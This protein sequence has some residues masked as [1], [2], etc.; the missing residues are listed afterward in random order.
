MREL[1]EIYDRLYRAYGPQGWWPLIKQDH[2][3]LKCRY[4]REN[5]VKK[6]SRQERFEICTG[7]ILTQNTS[8]NNAERALVSLAQAGILDA[9]AL[10]GM[11]VDRIAGYIRSSGYYNQKA[12]KLKAFS[13]FYQSNPTPQ[14]DLFLE[15]WGLGP[16]TVDDMLLYAYSKPI[17]VI[18]I[19][20]IRLFSRLGLCDEKIT[21]HEL[22]KSIMSHLPEDTLMY[23]EYH[24]LIVKHAKEHCRKNPN[25]QDCPLE[26]KCMEKVP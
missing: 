13:Q 26:K 3:G 25:C 22:Q 8:W 10:A 23:K 18:D 4:V 9:D 20:T 21:Y 14:R 15:Q 2:D 17:F 6:L 12:K 24:A 19:Y 11:D 1:T 16:E 7:A 5:S